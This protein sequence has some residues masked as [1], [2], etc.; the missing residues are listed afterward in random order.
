MIENVFD[1]P[2]PIPIKIP[3][4]LGDKSTAFTWNPTYTPALN[5]MAT[6]SMTTH[7]TARSLGRKPRTIRAKAGIKVPESGFGI[8]YE[9]NPSISN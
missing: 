3:E 7:K 5:P 2:F 4:K 1:V 8:N 6:I 9:N